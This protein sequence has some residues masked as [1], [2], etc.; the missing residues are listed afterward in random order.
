MVRLAQRVFATVR[1]EDAVDLA[2]VLSAYPTHKAV[3]LTLERMG[4]ATP[5]TWAAVVEAAWH[6]DNAGGSRRDALT[7][8]QSALALIARA[9]HVGSLD[10]A[11]AERLVLSLSAS[12]RAAERVPAGVR[13]WLTATWRSDAV[14]TDALAGPAPNAKRGVEWEGLSYELDVAAA[15]RERLTSMLRVLTAPSVEAALETD[16]AVA[17]ATALLAWTY[18]TALGDPSGAITLSPDLPLRH[19]FGL[20][21]TTLLQEKLPWA[22]AEEQQGTG[23]AWHVRGSLLGLDLALARLSLKHIA[24]DAMPPAPSLNLNDF[25]TFARTA[26]AMR[27]LRL[28]D[29][30]RDEI[31]AAIARGRNRTPPGTFVPLRD[32]MWLGHPNVP[33]DRLADWGMFAQALD[34]RLTLAMPR[35]RAWE[36]FA[37]RSDSGQLSTQLPDLTLRLAEET[38]R[39]RLPA[40]LVPGM[41]A[42]AVPDYWYGVNAR[43][44]DDYA[45]MTRAAAQVGAERAEDYVAALAGAGPLRLTER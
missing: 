13:S 31:V 30:D 10:S 38:A 36:D 21:R 42:S 25:A 17:L 2:V 39:L 43:F 23:R 19:D 45:R 24:D 15:E 11:G 29:D 28:R 26:V 18:A 27:P 33:E 6:V 16:D 40:A 3:L 7:T 37:G 9:R 12:V 22:M 32:L 41:L 44:N 1:I 35:R 8:F 34:G 4:I 20:H 5:S 14:L